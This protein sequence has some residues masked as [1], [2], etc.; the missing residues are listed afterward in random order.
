MSLLDDENIKSFSFQNIWHIEAFLNFSAKEHSKFYKALYKK[1]N[2]AK[3][4]IDIFHMH[5]FKQIEKS[6]MTPE[7]IELGQYLLLNYDFNDYRLN[8]EDYNLSELYK[9]CL[10]NDEHFA[11]CLLKKMRSAYIDRYASGDSYL[12]EKIITLHP[13]AFLDVFL[14]D[15]VELD[16]KLRWSYF[17]DSNR[18]PICS[19]SDDVVLGWVREKQKA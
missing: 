6:Q 13:T 16:R 10:P 17:N 4:A 8:G 7:Y 18:R 11:R 3:V 12:L 19:I 9:A 14:C 2:G 5:F 1:E 15:G